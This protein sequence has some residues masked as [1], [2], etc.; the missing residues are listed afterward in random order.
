MVSADYAVQAVKGIKKSFD[1][2][3]QNKLEV[4]MDNRVIDFYNTSEISEIFTSTEGLNGSKELTELETPP[5]LKLEDGYSVTLSEK[6]FGGAVVVPEGT[7]SRGVGDTSLKVKDFIM[8]QRNQLMKDNVNL[9]ITN[10]FAMYNEA[11]DAGSDYLAPDGVELCG[12]H[13]W[14]SGETFDNSDTQALDT[15]AVDAAVEDGAD[16]EDASGKPM[17]I[18]YDT[19]LV[20]KGSAAFR[21]A[22]KLFAEGITPTA[23]NDINIYEGEFIIVATPYITT[24]NKAYWFMLDSNLDRSVAV[25][26]GQAPMMHAPIIE[27]NQAVRSNVTG[28]WKQGILN[29]PFDIRGSNGTT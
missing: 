3:V 16:F 14:N 6:R 27:S 11:F 28:F 23:V 29:M 13:T 4:Y 21:T 9:L 8:R 26:I 10:A 19:I 7:Y 2:A 25:G 24:A 17:P 18:N 15:A 20:K 12:A 22:K 5:S 1:N